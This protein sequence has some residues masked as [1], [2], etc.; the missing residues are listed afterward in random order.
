MIANGQQKIAV[1]E[2]YFVEGGAGFG[3]GR[4]IQHGVYINIALNMVL[5]RT[6][7][8]GF[9]KLSLAMDTYFCRHKL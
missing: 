2:Y 9:E 3:F 6:G 4:T 5:K 8:V 1:S 7:S